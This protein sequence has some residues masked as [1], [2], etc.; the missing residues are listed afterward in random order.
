M[1]D[2]NDLAC[3]EC[4]ERL[5]AFQT[6]LLPESD[7]S[8]VD[9]HLA[10][11]TNCRLFSDQIDTTTDFIN[12]MPRGDSAQQL[13]ETLAHAV[14][15]TSQTDNPDEL[16]R[17]LCRLADSLDP[18]RA[19]DLVQRTFLAAVERD[20]QRLEL[21][22]LARD[23]IDKALAD[24]DRGLRGLDD[25]DWDQ[26][27]PAPDP[28]AD[29]AELYYPDFYETG[30]EIGQFVDAPNI[31]GRTNRLTPEEDIDTG[32]LYGVVDRAIEK[33]PVPLGQLVELVD[34]EQ[35]PLPEAASMLRLGPNDAAQA[36]NRAR[37]HVRG[38]V[39]AFIA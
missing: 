10:A 9:E 24:T 2:A 12:A 39:D 17:R 11:C 4:T 29:A 18:S 37:I 23:L 26:Q 16:L 15:S 28:D 30:P 20:P 32:E 25:F 13:A 22:E 31:W 7:A 36:L 38:A 14:P 5:T 35:I 3:V 34:I 33:L 19:E 8:V 6:G 21:Q 27:R 1:P